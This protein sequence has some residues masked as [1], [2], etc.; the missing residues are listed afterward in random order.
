MSSETTSE[1]FFE[2]Q[3]RRDPDPWSFATDNYEL[4]RYQATLTA[5]NGRYFHSAFE[6]GCSIG[7]LTEQLAGLC[8]HVAAID[9]SET[10]ARQAQQRCRGLRNVE[11]KH[12]ALP[13]GIPESSFDLIVFSEI[14]YYFDQAELTA[15]AETLVDRLVSG[16]VFLAVHWLGNSPDHT[17]T[18]DQVHQVLGSVPQLQHS[19]S[20]RYPGFRLDRWTKVCTV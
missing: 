16:G 7:V 5:L 11:V 8:E 14:G 20:Q 13:D 17:L 10:A 1:A 9:I 15:L 3:Y 12:A 4:S 18:G 2:A 19:L 6:P